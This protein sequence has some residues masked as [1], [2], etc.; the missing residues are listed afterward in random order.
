MGRGFG[1]SQVKIVIDIHVERKEKSTPEPV[2][3]EPTD[4]IRVGTGN[5]QN[6][7]AGYRDKSFRTPRTLGFS[8]ER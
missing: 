8:N 1:G 5:L 7:Q 6:G 4:D 2:K 3:E